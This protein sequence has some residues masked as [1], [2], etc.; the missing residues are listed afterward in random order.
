[1]NRSILTYKA[2]FTGII[3]SSVD[4]EALK[5]KLQ[6]KYQ[7][8]ERAVL[9]FF[10]NRELTIESDLSSLEAKKLCDDLHQW[11]MEIKLI[12]V[13]ECSQNLQ[14]KSQGINHLIARQKSEVFSNK[15]EKAPRIFSFDFTGRFNASHFLRAITIQALLSVF[16]FLFVIL[17][18]D[19]ELIDAIYSILLITWGF[20]T[21]RSV[22]LRLHDFN[23][24]NTGIQ[25]IAAIPLIF[26]IFG[27]FFLSI[28]F[29]IPLLWKKGS[30]EKNRFGLPLKPLGTLQN[31]FSICYYLI[32][33]FLMLILLLYLG[34]QEYSI[35]LIDY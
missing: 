34:D 31:I 4:K 29:Y 17:M 3:D 5:L 6:N 19:H 28:L 16:L 2:I 26:A 14:V 33:L 1:M 24:N 18:P 9:L 11:G 25:I 8:S 27:F 13:T 23:Q 32:S 12:A 21:V 30:P 22:I 7:L 15:L 10:Q 35:L 20:W